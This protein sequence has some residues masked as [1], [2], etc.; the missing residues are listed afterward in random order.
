MASC[1][2]RSARAHRDPITCAT[3]AGADGE[4]VFTGG[5]D[6]SI[7]KWSFASG[8][9]LLEYSGLRDK[10]AEGAPLPTVGGMHTADTE[11]ASGSRAGHCCKQ[12]WEICCKR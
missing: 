10:A 11:G 4:Y 5:K 7:I 9:R 3:V 2:V 6:G 8:K 12:R 1:E